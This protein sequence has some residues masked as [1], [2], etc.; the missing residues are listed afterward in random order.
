MTTPCRPVLRGPDGDEY[1]CS[2]IKTFPAEVQQISTWLVALPRPAARSWLTL[3][4]SD[5]PYSV[6]SSGVWAIVIQSPYR[7]GKLVRQFNLTAGSP[8]TGCHNGKGPSERL[9]GWLFWATTG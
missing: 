3:G 7:E 8:S 5:I 4:R 9:A 6:M 2:S 1:T